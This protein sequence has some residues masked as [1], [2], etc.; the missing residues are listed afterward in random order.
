MHLVDAHDLV[1]EAALVSPYGLHAELHVR[2]IGAVLGGRAAVRVVPVGPNGLLPHL[3]VHLGR[4][5]ALGARDGLVGPRLGG[6]GLRRLARLVE[7]PELRLQPPV[8][9]QQPAVLLAQ[10]AI[11]LSQGAGLRR[12]VRRSSCGALAGQQR[13]AGRRQ[14]HQGRALLVVAEAARAR[15]HDAVR[16]GPPTPAAALIG[17]R[18]QEARADGLLSQPLTRALPGPGDLPQLHV[19]LVAAPEEAVAHAQRVHGGRRLVGVQQPDP[20]AEVLPVGPGVLG[21]PV[22]APHDDHLRD[23]A[24]RCPHARVRVLHW[25]GIA[26]VV[27]LLQAALRNAAEEEVALALQL[28]LVVLRSLGHLKG[29]PC[30]HRTMGYL[31]RVNA[32]CWQAVR[33]TKVLY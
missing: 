1:V 27:L 24:E 3:A 31:I 20:E 22:G 19:L 18:H 26:L 15:A 25:L 32:P 11:L 23:L 28:G 2:R 29:C 6:R 5:V 8:L 21:Q 10:Q 33:C 30:D 13:A 14:Q 12:L 17:L 9:R 4:L 7:P 16:P